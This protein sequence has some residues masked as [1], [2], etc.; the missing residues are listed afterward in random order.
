MFALFVCLA[1]ALSIQALT[2]AVVCGARALADEAQGRGRLADIDS[3]LAALRDGTFETW[4]PSQWVPVDSETATLAGRL[5]QIEEGQDW[6]LRAEVGNG[7]ILSRAVTS[8]LVERGR[9]GLDLPAAALVAARVSCMEGRSTPWLATEVVDRGVE[10]SAGTGTVT[11]TA[12]G[13]SDARSAVGFGGRWACASLVGSGCSLDQLSSPWSLSDGWR[14]SLSA[15]Q[16]FGPRV[17]VLEG[18]AGEMLSA[19]EGLDASTKEHPVFV[20]VIGD[21]DLDLRA[22]GELW[23]VVV[24][25]G[26]SVMLE[27]TVV[28]GAVYAGDSVDFGYSGQV[29]FNPRVWR[30]A[31]DQSLVRVRLVPG[32]RQE[33]TE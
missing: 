19:P 7:Q 3:G 31:T 10:S 5:V 17:M 2:V 1:V 21:A 30:W 11:A 20:V 32:T 18:Q 24:V 29:V 27:Q 6:V 22:S 16:G 23:G 14:D 15:G 26:G 25:D 9:D 12:D 28:H 13:A 4:G 33:E 8:V